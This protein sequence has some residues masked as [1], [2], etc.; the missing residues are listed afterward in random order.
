VRQ[1]DP[2]LAR[3]KERLEPERQR[4]QMRG[5]VGCQLNLL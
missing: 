4:W 1:A 2:D 3:V 5:A